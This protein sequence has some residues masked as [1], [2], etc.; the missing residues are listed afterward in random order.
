MST[1]ARR[2]AGPGALLLV[3][4]LGSAWAWREAIPPLN[5]HSEKALA[6][7]VQSFWDLKIAGDVDTAYGFMA[8]AY[9]RR[10]TPAGFARQGQGVVVHTG[11]AVDGAQVD[12]DVAQV[13]LQL[14]HYFDRPNFREMEA[15][16]KVQDRWIF[17][18]GRWYRWPAGMRG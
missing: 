15:T 16:S 3:I 4:G 6:R 13:D 5:Q 9:R 18:N 8:E 7:R 1:R 11:A 14:R 12:G 10:V 17:E 2:F